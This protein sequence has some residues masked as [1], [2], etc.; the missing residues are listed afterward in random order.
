MRPKR[1]LST[2]GLAY[3]YATSKCGSSLSFP[4]QHT[5]EIVLSCDFETPFQCGY[6][7]DTDDDFDWRRNNGGTSSSATGPSIDHTYLSSSKCQCM[8]SLFLLLL[9]LLLLLFYLFVYF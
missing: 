5:A 2:S 4:S 9:L 8:K 1:L 7:Q 3:A 6:E